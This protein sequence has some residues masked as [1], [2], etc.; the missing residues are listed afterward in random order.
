MRATGTANLKK[1]A[2]VCSDHFNIDDFSSITQDRGCILRRLK[3]SAVPNQN[4]ANLTTSHVS[5]VFFFAI[6]KLNTKFM[7]KKN[8][9]ILY[10]IFITE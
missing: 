1:T 4:L 8:L 10:R 6:N 3:K 7:K 5:Y 9:R 2:S